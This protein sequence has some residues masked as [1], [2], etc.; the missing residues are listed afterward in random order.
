MFPV[1]N[2]FAANPS[3]TRVLQKAFSNGK[4]LFS[5]SKIKT[6]LTLQPRME[7]ILSS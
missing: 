5:F 7:Y 4:D 6:L 1:A 2:R 3:S